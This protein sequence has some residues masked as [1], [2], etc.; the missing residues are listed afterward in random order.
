M[1]WE[2]NNTFMYL[3]TGFE[4]MP[5]TIPVTVIFRIRVIQN[6]LNCNIPHMN[7]SFYILIDSNEHFII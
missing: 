3:N 5:K 2:K 6:D 7:I 1:D 4:N